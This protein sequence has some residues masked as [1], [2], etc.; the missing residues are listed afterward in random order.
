ML[1]ITSLAILG[2]GLLACNGGEPECAEDEELNDD[3]ECEE[4]E[5]TNTVETGDTSPPPDTSYEGWFF[6]SQGTVDT[7][8]NTYSGTSRTVDIDLLKS[9]GTELCRYEWP[10]SADDSNIPDLACENCAFAFDLQHTAGTKSGAYCDV[11]YAAADWDGH[12]WT[13]APEAQFD[14]AFFTIGFNADVDADEDASTPNEPA[15]MLLADPDTG[16][17][18]W[19]PVG[20]SNMELLTYSEA[21]GAFEYDFMYNYYAYEPN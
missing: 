19:Y 1:R 12:D 3:G 13:S 17:A 14:E 11:W 4:V 2:L 5:D 20:E 9:P 16:D 7:T 21:D 8:A 10:A 6:G 15:L 18:Y